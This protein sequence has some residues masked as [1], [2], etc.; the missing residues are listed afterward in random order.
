MTHIKQ[1]EQ[2][3]ERLLNAAGRR[4]SPPDEMRERVYAKTL[5]A[6]Q[7]LPER[8]EQP[9]PA[10]TLQS[11]H[12]LAMAATALLAL[13][14]G[15]VMLGDRNVADAGVLQ[16]AYVKGSI[17]LGNDRR[18]VSGAE[19][20]YPVNIQTDADSMVTVRTAAGVLLTV[21]QHAQLAV[22]QADE[23]E[24]R[25]GRIYVDAAGPRAAMAVTTRHARIVDVGTQFEVQVVEVAPGGEELLIA[26]REGRVD[27]HSGDDEFSIRAAAGQGELVKMSGSSVTEKDTIAATDARWN[28]RQAGREPYML[29]GSSVYDYLQWMARDTGHELHFNSNAV[30]Q[31]AKIGILRGPGSLSSDDTDIADALAATRFRLA[32]PREGQWVVHFRS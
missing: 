21:D 18:A 13:A 22:T 10:R 30:E 27:V 20:E 3:I 4:E 28:W 14:L 26:I 24:L 9:M 23:L 25:R 12:L 7:E 31:M 2:D 15:L 19:L 17:Q 32:R 1:D 29:A 6:W 11:S 5:Q 8:A 16:V